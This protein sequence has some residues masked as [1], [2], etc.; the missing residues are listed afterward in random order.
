ME[1]RLLVSLRYLRR[2]DPDGHDAL[3]ATLRRIVDRSSARA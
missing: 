2:H 1:R 3:V